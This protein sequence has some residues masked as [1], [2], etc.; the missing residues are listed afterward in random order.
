ML[1]LNKALKEPE[2]ESLNKEPRPFIGGR[3]VTMT[4]GIREVTLP[5]CLPWHPLR[6]FLFRGLAPLNRT[7]P[8]DGETERNLDYGS[9]LHIFPTKT[10]V[11]VW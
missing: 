11:V 8:C 2:Q 6:S 7:D 3:E 10:L 9:N 5:A 4:R 1:S